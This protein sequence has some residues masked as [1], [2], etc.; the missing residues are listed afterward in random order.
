MVLKLFF[1][2]PY[3]KDNARLFIVANDKKGLFPK[4]ATL[5]DYK[6]TNRDLRPVTKK[7]SRERLV[8]SE[9]IFEFQPDN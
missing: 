2:P 5:S 7:A 3:L 6:I 9:T 4:I 1:P 8:Y